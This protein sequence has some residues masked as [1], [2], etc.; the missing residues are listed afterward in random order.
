MSKM[1]VISALDIGTSKVISIVGELDTYGDIHIIG[2]GEVPSKGFDRG[3]IT[4]LDLAVS[5]IVNAVK[6]AQEMAS[7]KIENVVLGISGSNIK[8]QN[9]RDTLSISPQPVDI[10]QSHID[11]L[12]ERATTRAREEGYEVISYTPR[13]FT[14]DNQDGI[15]N[16]MGLFGSKLSAE[17]HV[18]KVSIGLLR[19]IERAVTLAG[20]RVTKIYVNGMASAE[21]VLTPEEKEEGVLLIDM[22][23]GL[24][25]FVLFSGG[26]PSVTGAIPTGSM[27]I[28]KD[29]AHFMKTSSDQAE[30]IKLES[31]YAIADLVNE[32]ERIKIKPRGEE[33]E[34]SISRRELAEVIQIRLEEISDEIVKS[35]SSKGY[36][37]DQINAGIVVTGG[38]AKLGGIREFFERFFDMPVRIGYP[39]GVI[40]LKERVQ[41]PAYSCSVGLL[42][43]AVKESL[44]KPHMNLIEKA[45][46]N[47]D[48]SFLSLIRKI[49]SFFRD[50]I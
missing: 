39:E 47:R 10:D 38:G 23:A 35:I 28:T 42:K 34:V 44:Y 11:R 29:I 1:K 36:S 45:G 24:T 18:V 8:S 49:K 37:L 26:F 3:N 48:S 17:V 25:D 27:N 12:M 16:P 50:V 32:S 41:D 6:E 43:L 5:S 21:A 22:G 13:N 14:L 7:V 2:V 46:N 33:R 20:L 19:N 30:K 31:G 15:I 40:G 4:R 9:E